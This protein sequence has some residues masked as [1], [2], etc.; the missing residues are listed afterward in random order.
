MNALPVKAPIADS[1]TNPPRPRVAQAAAEVVRPQHRA[2][3]AQVDE[4]ELVLDGPVEE[5]GHPVGGAG[6]VDDEPDVEVVGHRPHLVHHV[7]GREVDGH[8][9]GLDPVG[10]VDRVRRRRQLVEAPRHQHHVDAPGRRGHPEG[11]ADPVGA[12]RHH[13]PRPVPIHE[14]A[15]RPPRPAAAGGRAG[16]VHPPRDRRN[17]QDGP[18]RGREGGRWWSRCGP[19]SSTWRT[20]RADRPTARPSCCARVPLRRPRLRRGGRPPRRRRLPGGRAVAARLRPDPLR[21]RRHA[22]L[23]PAGRAG[24]G[25]AGAARRARHRAGRR[26]RLRLGRTGGLRGRR[27]CGPSGCSAWSRAGATT[28]ST[29]PARP[30]PQPPELEH[31]LWYQ[32]YFH[33]ERGRAGLAAEPP[34]VLPPAVAA[35]VAVVALH[36]RGVRADGRVVRQPRLRRRGDPLLPPP[37]RPRARRPGGRGRRGGA[38][39]PAGH[40]VPTVALEGADNGVQPA[41]GAERARPAFTGRYEVRAVPGVGHDVPQEAPAAFADA[42]RALLP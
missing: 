24:T 10:V 38:G 16:S 8:D 25:P 1:R 41:G 12:T 9:A 33:G 2:P 4:V 21:R 27:R 31:R 20:R 36:R 15:H 35:V 26:R 40:H 29:S 3:A 5:A 22:A 39:R 7:G 19:G 34:A 42:V 14:R 18:G 6:V 28:S 30:G 37:L 32:W 11:G 23:G 17:R 13:G